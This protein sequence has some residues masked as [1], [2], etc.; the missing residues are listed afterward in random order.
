MIGKAA[1]ALA[2]IAGIGAGSAAVP[3]DANA[4]RK[5]TK[6]ERAQMNRS[7]GTKWGTGSCRTYALIMRVSTVNPQ[8]A[9]L[10]SHNRVRD[11]R[12]CPVGDGFGVYRKRG[13]TY[14][15]LGDTSWTGA[16]CFLAPRRVALDLVADARRADIRRYGDSEF[17]RCG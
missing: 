14:R 13:K 2:V 15:H 16:P 8:Y 4:L 9:R 6:K 1:V 12:G 11:R 3:D 10:S 7:I 5:P 17:S